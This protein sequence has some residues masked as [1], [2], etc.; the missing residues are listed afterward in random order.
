MYCSASLFLK[1]RTL[2]SFGMNTSVYLHVRWIVRNF[3]YGFLISNIQIRPLPERIQKVRIVFS[4]V[5]R[6]D[7]SCLRWYDYL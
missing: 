5:V 4:H 7:T 3:G 1:E 6:R 2:R